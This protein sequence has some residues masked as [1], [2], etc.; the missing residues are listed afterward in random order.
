MVNRPVYIWWATMNIKDGSI[1]QTSACVL[2]CPVK[3]VGHIVACDMGP[4]VIIE[5]VASR[6]LQPKGQQV[7]WGNPG[8]LFLRSL[9]ELLVSNCVLH[10]Q[11]VAA[12]WKHQKSLFSRLVASC[13]WKN[14]LKCLAASNSD[15]HWV[16]HFV[17]CERIWI[18]FYRK[19]VI[20]WNISIF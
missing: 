19:F 2:L 13:L 14:I 6:H 11:M 17:F 7:T 20:C 5:F 12:D 15:I 16:F 18:L 8:C 4:K 9:R 3:P 10:K 1:W